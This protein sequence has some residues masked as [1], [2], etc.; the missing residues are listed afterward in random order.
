MEIETIFKLVTAAL[1]I[2][3]V[4]KIIYEFSTG[5]KNKLREEYRFAKEFLRDIAQEPKLHPLAIE[6]GYYAIAGTTSIKSKEIEYVLSLEN[7]DTCLKDYT[8]SRQYLE[9]IS[10]NGNF[11]IEFSQKYKSNFSRNW[12]K[13]VHVLVYF[14]GSFIALSPLLLFKPLGLNINQFMGLAIITMPVFGFFAFDSLKSFIKIKRGEKLVSSQS[15]HTKLIIVKNQ[16][17]NLMSN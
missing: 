1:G 8:L 7:P 2:F 15:K 11:K 9:H 4:A 16:S 3:G 6:K 14:F 13:T 5:S 17:V 10:Q 12:R